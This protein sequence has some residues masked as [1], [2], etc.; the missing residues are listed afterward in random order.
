[1]STPV[2][3]PSNHPNPNPAQANLHLTQASP[4]PTRAN[5]LTTTKPSDSHISEPFPSRT[6]EHLLPH[7]SNHL[8]PDTREHRRART[9][10]RLRPRTLRDLRTR[11]ERGAATA[12]YA[13]TIVAACGLGGILVALLKSPVMQN[14]LKALINYALKIAGVEGVHL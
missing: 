8:L 4:Q 3:A 13:V 2:V 11:T 5:P 7:I 14:A 9:L 12:E 1:M 6:P 10:R